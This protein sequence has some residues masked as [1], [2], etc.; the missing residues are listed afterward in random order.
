MMSIF[1]IPVMRIGTHNI[2]IRSLRWHFWGRIL[3][4][5]LLLDAQYLA[6]IID[7]TKKIRHLTRVCFI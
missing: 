7:I 6:K 3:I 1:I 5:I 2:V 4:T